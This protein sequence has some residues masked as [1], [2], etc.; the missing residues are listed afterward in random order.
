MASA[1]RWARARA[2]YLWTRPPL[3]RGLLAATDY[4]SRAPAPQAQMLFTS[5]AR[6][7]EAS[8][9]K[10]LVPRAKK[11]VFN[12]PFQ[13]C[14]PGSAARKPRAESATLVSVVLAHP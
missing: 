12:S 1:R 7:V 5:E 14:M 10:E 4:A 2:A 13:V 3:T 6:S 8:L 9:K 11:T